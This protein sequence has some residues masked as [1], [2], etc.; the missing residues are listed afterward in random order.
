MGWREEVISN[1][2]RFNQ[3]PVGVRQLHAEAPG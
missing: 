3:G 1:L 2:L